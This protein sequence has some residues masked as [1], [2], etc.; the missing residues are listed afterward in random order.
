[1]K[2]YFNNLQSE[3][4]NSIAISKAHELI[5]GQKNKYASKFEIVADA[6]FSTFFSTYELKKRKAIIDIKKILSEDFIIEKQQMDR[7][8]KESKKDW[9]AFQR[10]NLIIENHNPIFDPKT[11]SIIVRQRIDESMFKEQGRVIKISF[12]TDGPVKEINILPQKPS[13]GI[14]DLL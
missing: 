6:I 4:M 8:I 14:K 7:A 11:H 12:I 10:K 9:V 2:S 1:M 13:D 5:T 3:I